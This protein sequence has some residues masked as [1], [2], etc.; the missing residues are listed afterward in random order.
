MALVSIAAYHELQ[1]LRRNRDQAEALERLDEIEKEVA[2][3]NKDLSEEESIAMAVQLSRE[4]FQDYITRE[5]QRTETK[6][7]QSA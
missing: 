5:R 1:E 2:E 6:G 4:L 7:R 3:R